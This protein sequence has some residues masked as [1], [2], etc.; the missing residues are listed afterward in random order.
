MKGGMVLAVA[1]AIAAVVAGLYAQILSIVMIFGTLGALIAVAV[2]ALLSRR[3]VHCLGPDE[4]LLVQRFTSTMAH[5]GPGIVLVNPLGYRSCQVLKANTL[6]EMDYAKIQDNVSGLVRVVRGP[7]LI[8]LGA[9]ESLIRKEEAVSLSNIEYIIVTD[10]LTG[11]KSLVKGP[12]VWAP[13]PHD[14]ACSKQT[15]ISL[16]EDE[17]I[18]LRDTSNGKRWVRRGRAL[19]FLEPTWKIDGAKG[20]IGKAWVLKANEYVR[21]L[22]GIS[23]QVTVHRGERIA[24]P[25]PD[26]EV[27]DGGVQKAVEIDDQRAA[28]VRDDTT[29]QLQ[30]VREK[31][32]FVPGPNQTLVELRESIVLQEDEYIKLKDTATG[33]RWV[34]R[35]KALIFLEPTWKIDCPKA[36]AWVLKVNEYVRLLNGISGQVTVHRG[37]S[38]AFPGPDDVVLDGGVKKAVEIDEEHAALVRDETTGQLRLVTEKQLFVPGPNEKLVEVRKLIKLTDHEAMI[39]KDKDGVFNYYYGDEKRRAA[40]QPR[41][42]FL[43]PY[44]EVVKTK[45][46]RGA[47]RDKRDLIVDCFSSRPHMMR[48]EFTCR[49]ADHVELVVEGVVGWELVDLPTMFCTTGDPPGDICYQVRSSF[50]REVAKITLKAFMEEWHE[51]AKTVIKEKAFFSE[52]G[53]RVNALEIGRYY[54]A[55]KSTSEILEQIIQETTNRMNR[56]SQAESENEVNIFRTQGQT[57]QLELNGELLKIQHAQT[58]AEAQVSGKAE[59]DRVAAF[60][61]SLEA[62]VPSLEER[63]K[64]WQ[65]L[66]KTDALS[67]VSQ[68]DASLYFTPNDV[69]LS[70]ETKALK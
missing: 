27:L 32:L 51:I 4:Q 7:G 9:N 50:V 62:E 12:R 16:Q 64:M 66:R 43:P 6:G 68:G 53:L 26:D 48:I 54:C 57:Q 61:K 34:Q 5:N 17:F 47:R 1:V 69:D 55:D 22:N 67:V 35:G 3:A 41:S 21:L 18:K 58:E 52:R 60:L 20:N 38:I 46:S 42:F 59:A 39:I 63:I 19:V 30:L 29:G 70:I 45:W 24:F 28:L 56:L 33:K 65:V 13:G 14:S 11:E 49:T 25:G 15:A 8:F 37:E 44:A 31:Q 2:I 10:K 40:D 23:G 36:K